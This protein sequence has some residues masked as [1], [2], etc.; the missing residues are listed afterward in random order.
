MN[1]YT[2]TEHDRKRI[3]RKFNITVDLFLQPKEI[4]TFNISSDWFANK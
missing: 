1:K 4:E 3:A 2:G